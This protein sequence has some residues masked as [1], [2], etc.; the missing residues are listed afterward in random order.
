MTDRV[1]SELVDD[2]LLALMGHPNLDE[3]EMLDSID[4]AEGIDDLWQMRSYAERVEKA[5]AAIRRIADK[6]IATRL[7]G[8]AIRLGDMILRESTPHKW[9]P[10]DGEILFNWL[11]DDARRCFNPKNVQVTGIKAVA[12]DRGK[13]DE[14]V[15]NSLGERVAQRTRISAEQIDYAPKWTQRLADGERGSYKG[16]AR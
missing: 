13:D 2:D 15:L 16:G 7:D 14:V 6:E 9:E 4:G 8:E 10:F 5:A 3:V 12:K 1:P 11:G